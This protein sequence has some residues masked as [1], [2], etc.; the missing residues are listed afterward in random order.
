MTKGFRALIRT[1]LVILITLLPAT[2]LVQEQ[3]P[4]PAAPAKP[5]EE[6]APAKPGELNMPA[7]ERTEPSAEQ[8]QQQLSPTKPA[9]A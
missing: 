4:G 5:D 7:Q 1:L 3:T 9:G 2:A 8:A 6:A